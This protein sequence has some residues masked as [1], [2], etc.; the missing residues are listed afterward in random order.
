MLD[1]RYQWRPDGAPRLRLD[2]DWLGRQYRRGTGYAL[3]S[4]NH[5]GRAEV[6]AYPWLGRTAQLDVRVRGRYIHYRTPSSLEQD[7]RERGGALYLSSRGFGELSW[8]LGARTTSRAYPDSAAIDRD[9]VAVEGDLDRSAGG[10]HL[11]LYQRS[12]RRLAAQEDVRPSAWS[13]WSEVRA[14][15]PAGT[16]EV[17]TNL[18]SEVWR[19]DQQDDVWFDAWRLETEL[20][21]GWGNPL[22]ARW[23][24]LLTMERL[25]AGEASESYQQ[26][27]LRG[28][29][30]SYTGPVTGLLA[31]EYG[32]RWYRQEPAADT[33]VDSLLADLD[34]TYSDF[35]YLELWL[36]ATW[37]WSPHLSLEV[38]ASYQPEQHTEQDD[39]T[40]IGYGSA[41][42]VWRP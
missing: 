1:G 33:E 41:R 6:R 2:V 13:H 17:V 28:S 26:F 35:S 23:R 7:Y 10:R 31:L 21:Y 18:S 30:E 9:V 4:D 5:E 12:E 3:S 29:V 37:A 36:M 39:D 40:A 42:V 15:W 32:H 38:V 34:L 19:Y 11:W 20:G 14:S 8:R 25:D 16:G 22:Q 24:T 27:G